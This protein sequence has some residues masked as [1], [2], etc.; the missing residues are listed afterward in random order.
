ME[1]GHEGTA[2]CFRHS[3]WLPLRRRVQAALIRTG[4]PT[5]RRFRFMSCG[6]TYHV[7]ESKAEPGRYKLCANACH[8]RFCL[9]CANER[10]RLVAFNVREFTASYTLRFI[11]LTLRSDEQP[12]TELLAKLY[13][14]FKALRKLPIWRKSQAGGVAFL[15]VK[16]NP[17]TNRW[18]PHFHVLAAGKFLDQAKLSTAWKAVTG[19]SWV[20]DIR[21]VKEESHALAYCTKYASKPFDR[22]L[23]SSDERLDEAMTALQGRRMILTFGSWKGLRVTAKPQEG[24][25]ESVGTV[26][27]LARKAT[28]GDA[29]AM[30]ILIEVLGD[31]SIPFLQ[32]ATRADAFSTNTSIDWPDCY[33]VAKSHDLDP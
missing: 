21:A 29:R 6:S 27:E 23:L 13:D 26:A 2:I 31:R 17:K 8:D 28:S 12:L 11:T 18:H 7:L 19:D 14:S 3:G 15:E 9:P 20:C 4:Q 33:F 32:D 30:Q 24:E 22:D 10:A 1:V 25:W 5:T 16:W